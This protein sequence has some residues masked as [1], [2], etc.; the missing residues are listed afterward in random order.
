MGGK[1]WGG[2]GEIEGVRGGQGGGGAG[3]RRGFEVRGTLSFVPAGMTSL[4]NCLNFS[5]RL[6]LPCEG[7][8][9]KATASWTAPT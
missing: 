3:G 9:A 1:N 5:A 2:E 7:G 8:K 4:Q 6:A